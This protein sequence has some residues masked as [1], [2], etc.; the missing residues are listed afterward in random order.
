MTGEKYF[1]KIFI[2]S[3]LRCFKNQSTLKS[4]ATNKKIDMGLNRYKMELNY[5]FKEKI[6]GNTKNRNYSSER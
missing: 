5:Y 2:W 1:T 3:S 4:C 6:S